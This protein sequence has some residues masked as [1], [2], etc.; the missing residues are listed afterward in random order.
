MPFEVINSSQIETGDP[1]T[2]ELWS[3]TKN[4]LD[5]HEDR[6]SDLEAGASARE[7]LAFYVKGNYSS[8]GAVTGAAYRRLF[9]NI[10][11]TAGRLFVIDAG[12]AGTLDI[13]IQYKRGVSA[14]ATIFTTR[15]SVVYTDGDYYISTNGVLSV[16]S[17]QAGDILRLDIVTSQTGNEEFHV[18][19]PY[20]VTI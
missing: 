8:F 7:P 13:D 14:F 20:D 10:E 9:A 12:S 17:L 5:D 1:V 16:T 6:I 11:L 15:P 19:L 4:S 3:K 18:Y 2:A